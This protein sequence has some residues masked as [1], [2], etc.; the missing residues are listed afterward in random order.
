ME[1][2]LFFAITPDAS[3][4]ESCRLLASDLR[5]KLGLKGK[6]IPPE[7]LHV[8]LHHMGRHPAT[9]EYLLSTAKRIGAGLR[10]AP[11]EVGFDFIQ[12]FTKPRNQ[13][14]VLRGED[15]LLRG[16]KILQSE[17]ADGLRAAGLD[18]YVENRNMPHLTLLYD[19]K[20]A[21]PHGIPHPVSWLVREFHL[22]RS[23]IGQG[24]HETLATWAL[25]ER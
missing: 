10:M 8:T 16:V 20:G 23:L 13:P 17:L 22:I 5:K 4:M 21:P 6:L 15:R 7:R 3:A 14:V 19:D 11:F 18:Q 25:K 12:T 9:P 2:S 1:Q 24:K